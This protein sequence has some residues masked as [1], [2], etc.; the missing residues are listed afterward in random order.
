MAELLALPESK[1][2]DSLA[3]MVMI[4]AE[5]EFQ[6]VWEGNKAGKEEKKMKG[7]EKGEKGGKRDV[8]RKKL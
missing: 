4:G 6:G 1:A 8:K 2:E 7:E 5:G 3:E